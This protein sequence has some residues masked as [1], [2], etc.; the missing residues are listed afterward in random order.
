MNYIKI[1]GPGLLFA[2]A[3]IGT[4][5]L[6]LSTRAGAHYGISLL[7]IIIIALILKYPFFEFGT[8]Y[9]VATGESLVSGYKKQGGIA[10]GM[11]TL[12]ICINMFA[13]TGAVSAVS[14]GIL[15]T[16]IGLPVSITTMVAILL[17][18]TVVLLFFGGY[19]FLDTFIKILS[20]IL[21]LSVSI[22]F[23]AVLIK[24]PVEQSAGFSPPKLFDGAGIALLISLVGWMPAGME[25]STMNSIWVVKKWQSTN[26]RPTIKESMFDFRLGYGFTLLLAI[27]FLIIGAY[28]VYGSGQLLEGNGNQFSTALIEVL[29]ANLGQWAFPVIGIACFG[30]IYGT[31]VTVLDAFARSLVNCIQ[32]LSTTI[33]NKEKNQN[34]FYRIIL[35][36]IALGGFFL[37][38]L[39]SANMVKIL[40]FATVLSFITTPF[41]CYFNLKAINS[42]DVPVS[43]KPNSKL[44][45]LAYLGLIMNILFAA[46][47]LLYLINK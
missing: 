31:L 33:K 39:S 22:A 18:I 38:Y 17:S 28:T 24:G 45:Y 15:S 6:V 37:F 47:Y 7:W 3:A 11:F 13:V 30:V 42:K 25:A 8:R 23:I 4:S 32:E 9:A 46:F 20:V 29:T 10:L 40:E 34:Q 1:I 21:F 16:L 35:P 41:I 19:N 26:K 43:F 14:A 5:H 12:I 36:I 2:S 27:M 44:I